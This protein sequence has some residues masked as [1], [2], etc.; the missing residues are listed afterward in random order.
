METIPAYLKDTMEEIKYFEKVMDEA[1]MTH[2]ERI[3]Y[4]RSLKYYLDEI[5]SIEYYEAKGKAEG[6]AEGM[7]KEKI[8]SIRLMHSFGIPLKKI[9][10]GY[11]MSEEEID[12]ILA[13]KL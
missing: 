1:S 2:E 7:E 11:G 10:E 3:R 13:E 12:T 4:E 9:A 6:I 8:Q 5:D